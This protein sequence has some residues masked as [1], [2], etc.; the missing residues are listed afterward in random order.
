MRAQFSSS[1][2]SLWFGCTAWALSQLT[3]NEAE[4]ARSRSSWP[5]PSAAFTRRSTSARNVE[6]APCLVL[7]PTS[8]L[9]KHASTLTSRGFLAARNAL[10]DTKSH[11]RSSSLGD[12]TNSF[13]NPQTR[14]SWR[15]TRNRSLATTS[16][17]STPSSRATMRSK[18][19]R[20]SAPA[21]TSGHRS[22]WR[23]SSTPLFTSRFMCMATFGISSTSRSTLTRWLLTAPPSRTSTRPATESGRSSHVESIMPP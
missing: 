15:F 16:A 5:L 4:S 2:F 17:T 20:P 3:K 14:P 11:W 18:S 22:T 13:A 8:S 1:V 7:E 23:F 21:L 6:S 12:D 19:P 10:S 9:S